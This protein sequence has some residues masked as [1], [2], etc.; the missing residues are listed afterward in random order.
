MDASA[1]NLE[2]L[3]TEKESESIVVAK[4]S[5]RSGGRL[6]TSGIASGIYAGVSTAEVMIA[7]ERG[8]MHSRLC[9]PDAGAHRNACTASLKS[10]FHPIAIHPSVIPSAFAARYLVSTFGG[11]HLEE[12]IHRLRVGR[13]TCASE[14][15][16]GVQLLWWSRRLRLLSLL[17]SSRR[18]RR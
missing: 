5:N 17:C 1:C 3:R 10:L 11:A 7:L 12:L 9:L 14:M 6:I 18:Q 4:N 15:R 2:A 8:A 16:Q 13:T